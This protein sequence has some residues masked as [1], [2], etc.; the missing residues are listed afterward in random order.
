MAVNSRGGVCVD[1][2][3]TWLFD[4]ELVVFQVVQLPPGTLY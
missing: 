3:Y 4:I 1:E 2:R